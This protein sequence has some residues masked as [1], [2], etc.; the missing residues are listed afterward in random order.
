MSVR[1]LAVSTIATFVR[2]SGHHEIAIEQRVGDAT[3]RPLTGWFP[4]DAKIAPG[5]DE[6]ACY[7]G[8]QQDSTAR[9][10]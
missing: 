6:H 9:S 10:A 4:G 5:V 8:L 7:A 1:R 3:F 2:T